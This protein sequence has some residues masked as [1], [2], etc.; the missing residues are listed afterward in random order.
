M[1]SRNWQASQRVREESDMSDFYNEHVMR[2]HWETLKNRHLEI[3]ARAKQE[4]N[5]DS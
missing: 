1:N 4:S 5:H 3:Q 2:Y